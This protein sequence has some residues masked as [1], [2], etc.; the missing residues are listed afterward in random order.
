[1]AEYMTP[2]MLVRAAN[3]HME[4]HSLIFQEL[5]EAVL[6]LMWLCCLCRSSPRWPPSC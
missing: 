3:H 4:R 2:E 5:S 1:M 6:R